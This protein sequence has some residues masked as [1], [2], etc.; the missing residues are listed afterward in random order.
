[1]AVKEALREKETEDQGNTF[2]L[3]R[4]TRELQTE[5]LFVKSEYIIEWINNLEILNRNDIVKSKHEIS[6]INR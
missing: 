5:Y 4:L 3:L 1:M 6:K 2:Q